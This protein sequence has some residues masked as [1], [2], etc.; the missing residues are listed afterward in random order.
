MWSP[1]RVWGSAD[2]I[3]PSSQT[4]WRHQLCSKDWKRRVPLSRQPTLL[5]Y[6]RFLE[7]QE[8]RLELEMQCTQTRW[9]MCLWSP[10]ICACSEKNKDGVEQDGVFGV[11]VKLQTIIGDRV[12]QPPTCSDERD[13]LTRNLNFKCRM[14]CCMWCCMLYIIRYWHTI[15]YADIQYRIMTYNIVYC[16]MILY[17]DVQYHTSKYNIRQYNIICDINN[18]LVLDALT[19]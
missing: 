2:K 3:S 1:C 17:V 15:S 6:G 4:Y 13:H 10:C 11:M 7:H 12:S 16:H 14:W 5:K 19:K 18:V 9:C 8:D